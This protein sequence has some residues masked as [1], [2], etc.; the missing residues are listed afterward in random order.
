MIIDHRYLYL[1]ITATWN[2]QPGSWGHVSSLAGFWHHLRRGDYGTFRLFSSLEATEGVWER[3]QLYFCDLHLNQGLYVLI[4]LALIGTISSLYIPRL[5]TNMSFQT[6][7][8]KSVISG[9]IMKRDVAILIVV[10]YIFYIVGF[11]ALSNLP[12]SQGLTYGVHMR[13]WQQPNI[14]VFFFMGEGLWRILNSIDRAT[15]LANIV[16]LG[17]TAIV[18]LQLYRWYFLMDQSESWYVKWYARALLDPLPRRAI[19]IVNYDLQW[20]SLRY[21]QECEMIRGDVTLL[22][23]SMMTYSWFY[24]KRSQYPS[25]IFP[26]ARLSLDPVRFR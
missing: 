4:P 20:T 8:H 10:S 13:F 9:L 23:L 6:K 14:L 21:L 17:C 5:Q 18:L 7:A 24:H 2:P 25:L 26:G 15:Q 1:P 22:N 3:I 19:L 11:H 12:L 16:S